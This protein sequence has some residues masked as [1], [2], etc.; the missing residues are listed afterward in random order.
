MAIHL[1][2]QDQEENIKDL[3]TGICYMGGSEFPLPLIHN[4]DVI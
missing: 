1:S 2:T 3:Q 4:L